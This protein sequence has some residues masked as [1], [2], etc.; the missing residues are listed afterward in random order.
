MYDNYELMGGKLHLYRRE[1]STNWQCSTYL[2]GK[3]WR[4]STKEDSFGIARAIAEDWYLELK[5][6]MRGGE[7]K[8]GKTFKDAAEK[9]LPEYKALTY[10]E[11]SPQYVE[12][13][14][15]LIRTH[16]LPFFGPRLLSEI[17]PGMV[18]EY[19]IHRMTSRIDRKTGVPKRPARS[20]LLHELVALRHVLNTANRHGWLPVLPDLTTPYKMSGK[21]RTSCM[22]LTRRIQAAV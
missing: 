9:F 7:L 1:N 21:N 13:L 12:I 14:D 20:T 16:L 17:T 2:G 18:Q 11:R 8:V 22:V 5:G 19:R 6:K 15:L 3:N 10:G 4:K